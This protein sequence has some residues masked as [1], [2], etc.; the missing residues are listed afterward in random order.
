MKTLKLMVSL[1]I[2]GAITFSCK[3]NKKESDAVEEGA[4][5]QTE[6]KVDIVGKELT[7]AT[8]TTQMKGYIVFDDALAEKRPGVLVVHEW[9]GHNDYSRKRAEMLAELG[10]TALAVDMYGDGKQAD[11][12]DDAGK[13][14]G[15]VMSNMP[16]AKARFMAAMGQ[17]KNHPSVDST[18][19]AAIGYCFGGSVVLTMA[20]AGMDLDAVAAFHSGVALPVMPN[21]DLKAKVLVCNGADDPFIS[22]ESVE[23][24][25]KKMDS[26]GADYKYIAYEGAKHSFTSKEADANGE[27]FNLPLAYNEK[28]NQASWE[29][30]KSLLNEA[31]E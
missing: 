12:P 24:F 4:M 5:D 11:H 9:W 17:L 8:D 16:A 21:E 29:E 18:K 26:I 31:F 19:I 10:Y 28:A 3:E 1:A 20:N 13:F 27:K 22:E 7:Y 30:L 2:I 6:A 23:T 14:A 15:M 25:K